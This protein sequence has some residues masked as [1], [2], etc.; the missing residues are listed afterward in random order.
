MMQHNLISNQL[1]LF[2][3]GRIDSSNASAAEAEVFELIDSHPQADP[4][5]DCGQLDY[6]SS[7]GLR[8]I[9]H[10][11]KRR[12]SLK[13]TNVTPDVYDILEM[14]GFT[15][16][17]PVEKG[18]R[19]I[20]VDGCQLIGAGANGA[21]YRLNA[22][23]GIKVYKQADALPEIRRERELAR[24]A[25]I[26]GI[27]TAIPYDVVRVGEGYG[28]VF[29]LLDA[30]SF[31][32]I[33]AE[34][35]ER[36]EELVRRSIELM[37]KLHTT[38]FDPGEI[39]DM[40]RRALRWTDFLSDWLPAEL[41]ARL[42][43]LVSDIPEDHRLLHGDLHFNNIML[44]RG[45]ALLIDM[46]T[47]ALGHPVFELASVY[48]AYLGYSALKP[49]MSQAFYGFDHATADDVWKATLKEYFA[50]RDSSEQALIEKKIRTV[51]LTRIMRWNIRR[52]GTES[53]DGRAA[54]E[55]CRR[56]FARLLPELD[57]LVFD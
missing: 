14:T 26:A 56:E 22:D 50:D 51:A 41:F 11:L 36:L 55:Y 33:L 46:D 25:F 38:Q 27:P 12:P 43:E 40:K 42:K 7:A 39:P 45:E 29:E 19:R 52:L 49:Q 21:L 31:A 23:T 15:E 10:L 35:P 4:V 9:L 48:A 3:V 24:K 16:M 2:P 5:L 32:E 18:F 8:V 1:T 47:L 54:F 20:S 6:V 37:K 44:Q 34:E 30:R 13:L 17:L 57:S 53:P 28:T